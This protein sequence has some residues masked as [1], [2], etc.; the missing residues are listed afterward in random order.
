MKTAE[1]I[2]NKEWD[3]YKLNGK[4]FKDIALDAMKEYATQFI[5]EAI[6]KTEICCN[7]FYPTISGAE[8]LRI[9]KLI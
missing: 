3:N 9:K 8:L 5:D 6:N 2:L 7:N 1:E 4:S